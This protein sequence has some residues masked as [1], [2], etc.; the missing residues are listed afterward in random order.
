MYFFYLVHRSL[1]LGGCGEATYPTEHIE[2]SVVGEDYFYSHLAHPFPN[3][4]DGIEKC[5]IWPQFSILFYF[6]STAFQI[7]A[8]YRKSKTKIVN[9]PRWPSVL[10]NVV[11]F[12]FTHLRESSS[13][14]C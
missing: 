3:F 5:E 9:A 8:R 13:S 10:P 11:Q 14:W 12:G 1:A 6:K 2:G 4:D 7:G